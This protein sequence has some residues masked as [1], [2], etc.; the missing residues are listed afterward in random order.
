[1]LACV[2]QPTE[3]ALLF[4]GGPPVT[5]GP[6]GS[7]GKMRQN[8]NDVINT[9]SLF[10]NS[11]HKKINEEI[12]DNSPSITPLPI[13]VD[14]S[15]NFLN[16]RKIERKAKSTKI[17]VNP[18]CT[19]SVSDDSNASKPAS[20]KWNGKKKRLKIAFVKTENKGDLNSEQRAI[21]RDEAKQDKKPI[22]CFKIKSWEDK[23]RTNED[24]NSGWENCK[25]ENASNSMSAEKPDL[26][27]HSRKN[28]KDNLIDEGTMT[29]ASLEAGQFPRKIDTAAIVN[30]GKLL[31][32]KKYTEHE[33]P[34]RIGT[35]VHIKAYDPGPLMN[36]HPDTE[37]HS[38]SSHKYFPVVGIE[39]KALDSESKVA[40]HCANRLLTTMVVSTLLTQR[41]EQH[42]LNSTATPHNKALIMTQC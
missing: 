28:S 3:T 10:P 6:L 30:E 15:G 39:P 35:G 31:V 24:R 8:A 2:C 18:V 11:E 27:R 4:K 29:D 22:S 7:S 40:A 13:Y 25:N 17:L 1:M 21:S 38:S 9:M 23:S 5:M 26:I 34:K 33:K 41:L 36:K 37:K 14:S 19:D 16:L 32:D 42:T 12:K 20:T